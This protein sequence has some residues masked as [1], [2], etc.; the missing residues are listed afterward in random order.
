VQPKNIL[1]SL[2]NLSNDVLLTKTAAMRCS[3]LLNSTGALF[4]SEIIARFWHQRP[5]S[6]GELYLLRTGGTRREIDLC[7][8]V[9]ALMKSSPCVD[10][11]SEQREKD[12]KIRKT[13]KDPSPGAAGRPRAR[14]GQQAASCSTPL[15]SLV[16][17]SA[18]HAGGHLL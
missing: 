10:A 5:V 13:E 1:Q 17:S 6:E 9:R 2:S 11:F 8:F 12:A 15:D 7:L 18:V 4:I 14:A 3:L 16:P